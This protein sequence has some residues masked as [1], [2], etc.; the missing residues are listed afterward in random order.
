[1]TTPPIYELI[2]ELKD[3]DKYVKQD[4]KVAVIGFG[5]MGVLH[6][7]ILNLLKPLLVKMIADKNHLT[8]IG[9]SKLIRNIRFYRDA[10]KMLEKEEPDVC[11]VTTPVV[12]HYP[13]ISNLLEVGIKHIFVEKPPTLNL[14]QLDA[15]LDKV[16]ANHVIMIGLQKRYAL[17]FRHAKMLLSKNNLG[18][19]KRVSAYIK[20][21]DIMTPT[22]RFK[23]I[24]RGVLLDLGI[25]L[26]DLLQWLVGLES[27]KEATYEKKYT[28]VDDYFK[29]ILKTTHDV[30]V[31]I[32][33]TWSDPSYRLPETYIEIHG[34][35]GMLKVTEDYLKVKV[36][37]G[38]NLVM[39]KPHY[40]Q[41]VPPVNL[42]DPEFTLENI[43]FLY[44]IYK[45]KQP[46]TNLKNV[47]RTMELIDELYAE[48]GM[49]RG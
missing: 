41:G 2:P 33:V 11:Y 44:S 4:L 9:F 35:N 23:R 34:T 19:I 7:V 28:N 21:S 8:I 20:S 1:M 18:D 29:A 14:T 49:N 31:N 6:S 13:I 46:L 10:N 37:D 30:D 15:L 47:R 26:V 24:G 25:H 36:K 40:Y 12:S 45:S 22:D 32:K 3:Y 48:A 39:F 42:A 27:V 16:S 17:P 38:E 5:K 43:H